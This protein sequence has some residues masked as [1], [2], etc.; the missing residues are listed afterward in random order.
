[1]PLA[2]FQGN[3]HAASDRAAATVL[4]VI[5]LVLVLMV[6]WWILDPVGFAA[7]WDNLGRALSGRR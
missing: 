7:F 1:M 5:L 3:I 4:F 2:R 6:F